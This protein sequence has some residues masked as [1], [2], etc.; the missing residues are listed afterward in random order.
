MPFL[1]DKLHVRINNMKKRTIIACAFGMQLLIGVV[2]GV[3]Q[4]STLLIGLHSTSINW[5][6]AFIIPVFGIPFNTG[7]FTTRIIFETLV[8]PLELFIGHRSATVMSNLPFYLSLL[9][10][11]MTLVSILIFARYQR[12]KTSKDWFII[13]ISISLL[14]NG[15]MNVMWPWWGT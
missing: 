7:G 9:A 13:A 5:I 12:I 4:A 6:D 14:A 1:P 8:E 2:V 15:L 3:V 10:L 11:Q